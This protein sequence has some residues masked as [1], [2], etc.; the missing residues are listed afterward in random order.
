MNWKEK[1]PIGSQWKC[2]D[3]SRAVVVDIDEDVNDNDNTVLFVFNLKEECAYWHYKDGASVYGRNHDLSI[4]SEWKEPRV[5]EVDIL[6]GEHTENGRIAI[7]GE[8]DFCNPLYKIIARKKV[9]IIEGEG[10]DDGKV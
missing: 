5:Y 3:G 2:R 10:M 6:V 1:F 7:C 9:T 8:D 4:V